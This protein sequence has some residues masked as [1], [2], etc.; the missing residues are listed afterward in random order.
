MVIHHTWED[1]HI[2]RVDWAG[3]QI[4]ETRRYY[5]YSDDGHEVGSILSGW[6]PICKPMKIY[7]EGDRHY[8]LR[9]DGSRHYLTPIQ[10]DKA[11]GLENDD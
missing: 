2:W 6:A 11:F 3:H 4:C 1:D 5:T 9:N 8:I 10:E 7:R